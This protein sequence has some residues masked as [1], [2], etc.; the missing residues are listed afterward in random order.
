MPATPG[1]GAGEIPAASTRVLAWRFDLE[2]EAFALLEYNDAPD[3]LPPGLTQ[4][5]A[6]VAILAAGGHSNRE[7]AARR[8][9]SPRTVANQVGSIFHKL[10]VGSRQELVVRLRQAPE[11]TR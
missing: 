8:G 3:D 11:T 4:A 6:D 1:P 10:G 2:G 7:I 5:E 9:T